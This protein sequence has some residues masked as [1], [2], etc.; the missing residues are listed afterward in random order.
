MI[1]YPSNLDEG[2]IMKDVTLNLW[3]QRLAR[4][5]PFDENDREIEQAKR[6][7]MPNDGMVN[8][9]FRNTPV[10]EGTALTLM[11]WGTSGS[12]KTKFEFIEVI[13]KMAYAQL[14][15]IDS[16]REQG[17]TDEEIIEALKEKGFTN[18]KVM[19]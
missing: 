7:I 18:A 5:N 14:F 16:W 19:E 13:C 1:K 11:N 6:F 8:V 2:N 15:G 3:K 4:C 12:G 10:G 9:Q 17:M